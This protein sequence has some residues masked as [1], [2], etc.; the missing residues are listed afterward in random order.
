METSG[1]S[2]MR[3]PAKGVMPKNLRWP[4]AAFTL[5]SLAYFAFLFHP[6]MLRYDDFGYLQSVI[7]TLERGRPH[8]HD[9]LAPYTAAS[10][11]LSALA[12]RVTGDFPLSTWGLQAA[13]VLANFILLYRIL[14]TRLPPGPSAWL[15]LLIA[16]QPIYWYK[17]AE[18][19]GNIFT[20]TFVLAAFWAYLHGRWALFFA[21]AFLAF[22]NRQNSVALLVLPLYHILRDGKGAR[23]A[24]LVAGLLAFAIGGAGLHVAMNRSFAQVHSIYGGI[25]RTMAAGIVKSIFVGIYIG[26]AY[27]S[28]FRW[29]LGSRALE[30][31]RIN[32][33]K[34]W[35]PGAATVLFACIPMAGSLP[36]VDFQAPFIG[37]LDHAHGIQY[38]LIVIIP[39][40]LW[41]LDWRAL[42]FDAAFCLCG[43]YIVLTSMRGFWFDIYLLDVGLAVLVFVLR[44]EPLPGPGKPSLAF[45]LV[46]LAAHL[47]WAYGFKIMSDKNALSN[48]VYEKLERLD[49]VQVENMTDATFG[50]AGW[51]L[52]DYSRD[53]EP[54]TQ[55][56][57]FL[58]HIHKDRVVLE[59]E[60]PWRREFKRGAPDGAEILEQ[61]A[62]P[63]G[64]FHLRYRVMDLHAGE[65]W[66]IAQGRFLSL[67]V[68]KYREKIFPLNR[69]EW[70][71][72]IRSLSVPAHVRPAE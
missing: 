56:A 60:L 24:F 44:G 34:P 21:A 25:D 19:G 48:Q 65:D 6:G 49:K 20:F 37:S 2:L 26:L 9:W 28:F 1:F 22:A 35:I 13:F 52:F 67:D 23:K 70:S 61:G 72:Y 45:I 3:S 39:A 57:G 46:L 30:N 54:F 47:G 66:S 17:C 50:Y 31:L 29:L 51:K 71:D 41:I 64:F 16:S 10:S 11:T 69:K 33:R 27:L 38:A 12:Y 4:I 55:F 36:L 58:R 42:R 5:Y 32:L 15:S 40:L 14:R 8:T 68:E 59:T 7:E 62:A 53:N 18:F 63:I 43:A